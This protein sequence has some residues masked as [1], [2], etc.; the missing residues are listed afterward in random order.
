MLIFFYFQ[1]PGVNAIKSFQFFIDNSAKKAR[2]LVPFN[3]LEAREILS[4][5]ARAHYKK[6][7]TGAYQI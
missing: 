1:K 6:Q 7:L 4:G 5:K 3:F 2:V